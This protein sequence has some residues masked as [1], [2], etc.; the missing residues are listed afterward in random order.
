MS[1]SGTRK[2]SR[3]GETGHNIQTCPVPSGHPVMLGVSFDSGQGQWQ[4]N[5]SVCGWSGDWH[6]VRD[7]AQAEAM[8]HHEDTRG[9]F[10][11]W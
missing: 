8:S 7:E 3:C 5:C 4:P 2:C 1:P 6:A 11:G 9:D 10:S